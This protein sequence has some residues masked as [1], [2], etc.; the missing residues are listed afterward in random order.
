MAPRTFVDSTRGRQSQANCHRPGQDLEKT[1]P[2]HP[3]QL[4]EQDADEQDDRPPPASPDSSAGD[5]LPREDP[6]R[7]LTLCAHPILL[8]VQEDASP[9]LP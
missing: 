3:E 9:L 2:P 7:Q 8:R 1:V 6:D 4:D 5:S